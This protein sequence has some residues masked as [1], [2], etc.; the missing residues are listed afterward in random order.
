MSL[1]QTITNYLKRSSFFLPILDTNNYLHLR[2]RYIERTLSESNEI[3]TTT[4]LFRKSPLVLIQGEGGLGKSTLLITEYEKYKKALLDLVMN[5]A[6]QDFLNNKNTMLLIPLFIPL[7]KYKSGCNH[8]YTI[9]TCLLNALQQ[10]MPDGTMVDQQLITLHECLR[11]LAPYQYRFVLFLDAYDEMLSNERLNFHEEL[12]GLIKKMNGHFDVFITSRCAMSDK[13]A[14]LVTVELNPLTPNDVYNVL[15]NENRI[16]AGKHQQVIPLPQEDTSLFQMIRNPQN[17]A[18]YTSLHGEKY[19]DFGDADYREQIETMGDLIWNFSVSDFFNKYPCAAIGTDKYTAFTFMQL[20]ILPYIA[21]RLQCKNLKENSN[22][23]FFT[24]AEIADACKEFKQYYFLADKTRVFFQDRNLP[25]LDTNQLSEALHASIFIQCYD[26]INHDQ[27]VLLMP[28]NPLMLQGSTAY[29]F[30]HKVFFDFCVS[31]HL[32]NL[33]H[34]YITAKQEEDIE[35]DTSYL[36]ALEFEHTPFCQDEASLFY[37]LISYHEYGF[38]VDPYE[39]LVDD[40]RTQYLW[41]TE[42]NRL[43]RSDFLCQIRNSICD[44]QHF[45]RLY[46]EVGAVILFDVLEEFIVKVKR[47][48]LDIYGNSV[49]FKNCNIPELEKMLFL[50]LTHMAD[51]LQEPGLLARIASVYREGYI[52]SVPNTERVVEID[53]NSCLQFAE[54]SIKFGTETTPYTRH[55]LVNSDNNVRGYNQKA[56][57]INKEL[58]MAIAW[59]IDTSSASYR[60]SIDIDVLMKF[61]N[62]DL[63]D[64]VNNTFIDK[65]EFGRAKE[66]TISLFKQKSGMGWN[67]DDVKNYCIWL[68]GLVAIYLCYAIKAGSGESG[69]LLAQLIENRA[70]G[71]NKPELNDLAYNLFRKTAIGHS[72]VSGYAAGKAGMMIVSNE[73]LIPVLNDKISELKMHTRIALQFGNWTGN[74]LLAQCNILQCNDDTPNREQWNTYHVRALIE[75]RKCPNYMPVILAKL[76]I[77]C[78]YDNTEKEI[79]QVFIAGVEQL[80]RLMN[81]VSV[82]AFKREV[83]YASATIIK[84]YKK[85]LESY[86]IYI[87]NH[88]QQ[89]S[90]N[91]MQIQTAMQDLSKISPD[92]AP[93]SFKQFY[94]Y[95]F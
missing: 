43:N 75:L 56:K 63:D 11:S 14:T 18:M 79:E 90:S 7:R 81:P 72:T 95:L 9:I 5:N 65:N 47:R 32:Y 67:R 60:P 85:K 10:A 12:N 82:A 44:N 73:K 38:V 52:I 40:Y 91:T 1:C 33:I 19:R 26:N 55:R 17:L 34:F 66:Y 45:S 64:L 21:Y 88:G 68:D 39:I 59:Y 15:N 62:V 76:S 30:R 22:T 51:D 35:N 57:C 77:L 49:V 31:K 80:Q 41:S 84:D 37:E 24:R 86:A 8:Q 93:Y 58:E 2:T 94:F 70:D 16:R 61:T 78:K 3:I 27:A 23:D 36:L 46:R 71:L 74:Y 42:I 6:E 28:E 20:Y 54:R 92:K 87:K 29:Q 4:A 13:P 83:W 53:L 69:S 25:F 89:Q 48:K 50:L